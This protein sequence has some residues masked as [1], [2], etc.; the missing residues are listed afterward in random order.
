MADLLS[1]IQYLNQQRFGLPTEADV[2]AEGQRLD[3]EKQLER[4]NY[5]RLVAEDKVGIQ[6]FSFLF[7]LDTQNPDALVSK[8]VAPADVVPT[9]FLTKAG[10]GL[11]S[12][13]GA[14][15]I[16]KNMLQNPPGPGTLGMNMY[17]GTPK[18]WSSNYPDP[19]ENIIGMY[20][21]GVYFGGTPSVSEPFGD[22]IYKFD[23]PDD[24]VSQLAEY[25]GAFFGNEKLTNIFDRVK[26][27]LLDGASESF[28]KDSPEKLQ[29]VKRLL[30]ELEF[31]VNNEPYYMFGQF[32]KQLDQ[33]M[34]NVL[35]DRSAGRA[36]TTKLLSDSGASGA[37]FEYGFKGD[38]DSLERG[39]GFVVW[40]T[41]I[42]NK[43]PIQE[44]LKR[45]S[46]DTTYATN[47][48]NWK[49]AQSKISFKQ[50]MKSWAENKQAE[51]FN[52][53]KKALFP[54]AAVAGGAA[55]LALPA[56]AVVGFNQ[57]YRDAWVNDPELQGIIPLSENVPPVKE[58]IHNAIMDFSRL[59]LPGEAKYAL[60]QKRANYANMQ[61]KLKAIYNE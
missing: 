47:Y 7:G 36:A 61:S 59:N 3:A 23:F 41:D 22:I 44:T 52:I 51:V 31:K 17:H 28:G 6:P 1:Q 35:G 54:I 16:G 26:K 20:G 49:K 42:L 60:D 14:G 46:D 38:P 24:K 4:E 53:G 13:L 50:A 8:Y 9:S 43:M 58:Y 29:Y 57:D 56:A 40:D 21:P 10:I 5:R 34:S 2:I 25:H 12:G 39:E 18:E 15:L 37:S 11:L 30:E 27:N 45:Q 32:T 19:S 48:F 55:S 33:A